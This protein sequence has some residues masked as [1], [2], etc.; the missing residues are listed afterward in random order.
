M[1]GSRPR[2]VLDIVRAQL[3]AAYSHTSRAQALAASLFL[4][5]IVL[6]LMAATPTFAQSL[7]EIL[8]QTGVVQ[9][10]GAPTAGPSPSSPQK[11][12]KRAGSA[13]PQ[14]TFDPKMPL[15]WLGTSAGPYSYEDT[16]LEQA[17]AWSKGAIVDIQYGLSQLLLL[18]RAAGSGGRLREQRHAQWW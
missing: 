15:F 17:T 13:A 14:V 8:G 6:A 10:K 9:V 18:C 11:H 4:L 5:L 12:D 3:L 7:R 1:A 2:S 16:E